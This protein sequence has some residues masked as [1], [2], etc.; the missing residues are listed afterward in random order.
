MLWFASSLTLRRMRPVSDSSAFVVYGDSRQPITRAM[1]RLC[2]TTMVQ[3]S[4]SRCQR[5]SLTRLLQPDPNT[6]AAVLP[7]CNRY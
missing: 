1:L 7:Q 5:L 2:W 4:S 6:P 3:R